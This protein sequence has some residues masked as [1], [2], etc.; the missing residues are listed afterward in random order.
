MSHLHE[1]KIKFLEEKANLVRQSLIEELVEAGSGHT[2]GPLG[3]ADIFT[4][5]YFHILNHDAKNPAWEERDRLILSNGHIVPIRYA[6]MAHAG[7]FPL[8]ELKTLR[9]FG[10][11]LQ[12]H[13]ERP[14]MPALESTSGPLGSGLGQAAGVALAA[15]MDGKKFRV[16]CIMSD[17]EQDAGNI[18]ESAMFAGANKLSNLTA[19]LDRN[20]IQINGMTE[21]VMPLEPIREKYEAFGWHVID[22]DGHNMEE[23]VDGVE[24]AKAIY[25][26]PTLIIAH[27]IP[28]KGV[29]EIEFDY[30]WHGK[31]P[32]PEE[33]EKFLAELRTLG[34]KIKSEHE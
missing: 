8:E 7:Y 5:L 13:P 2:A 17:G 12:G 34:G 27:V 10:T 1:D 3:M 28:G 32:K 31:S 15:R 11:R 4:A 9:K 29:K 21:N 14:I 26:K 22:I 25:E 24:Q 33:A 20:N 30:I 6:V 23:I 19:I 16:Y 18:W